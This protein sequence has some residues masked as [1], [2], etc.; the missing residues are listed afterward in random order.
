[1]NDFSPKGDDCWHS[2]FRPVEVV[3][4]TGCGTH[5]WFRLLC[6]GLNLPEGAVNTFTDDD[7]SIFEADIAKVA[8]AG[9]TRGCS[10]DGTRF[11]PDDPVTRGQMAAFIHRALATD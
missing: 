4:D 6:E 8:E 2:G 7:G 11:C 5:L 9:I 10:S 1:M 3:V